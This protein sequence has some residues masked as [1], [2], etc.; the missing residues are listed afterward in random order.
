[1]I[2]KIDISDL[3]RNEK[4]WNKLSIQERRDFLDKKGWA[5]IN[6]SNYKWFDLHTGLKIFIDKNR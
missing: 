2:I 4:W 6:W 1:M 3:D 5:D